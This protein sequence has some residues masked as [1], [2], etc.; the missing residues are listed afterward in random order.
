MTQCL[1]RICFDGEDTPTNP[2]LRPCHCR[3]TMAHVHVECLNEWR[4]RSANPRSFYQCDTCKFQYKFGTIAGADRFSIS[5]MLGRPHVVH[6]LSLAG[7][8]ALVFAGGFVAKSFDATLTW[9]DVFA[10]FNIN[11]LLS[12]ATATGLISLLGWFTAGAGLGGGGGYVRHWLGDTWHLGGGGGG[13]G[14]GGRD[15]FSTILLVIAVLAGLCVALHWI[16]GRLETLS[17]KTVRMAQHVV[18]DVGGEDDERTG[19]TA[20]ASAVAAAK[21]AADGTMAVGAAV[22]YTDAAGAQQAA[23]VLAVHPGPP[24]DPTPFYTIALLGGNRRDTEAARLQPRQEGNR[25]VY[26]FVD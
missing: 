25:A 20:S 15:A 2:L 21:P 24:D 18:L 11:H 17:R 4:K 7:L 19:E 22:T 5:H 6:M 10:C 26:E 16:Y 12:G 23:R 9:Y 13:R 3:G 1:C 8:F 14:G